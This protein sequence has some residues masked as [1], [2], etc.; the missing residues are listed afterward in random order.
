[1]LLVIDVGNT[2]IALAGFDGERLC[3]RLRI[4]AQKFADLP[5]LW[6]GGSHWMKAPIGAAVVCSVNPPAAR[7]ITYWLRKQHSIVAQTIGAEIPVKMP[8]RC[9]RPEQVGAD[10]LANAV[11]AFAK[12]QSHVVVVDFGTATSFDIVSDRGEF[13]GGVIAP[14]I[15]MSAR[16]LNRET[17]FLPLVPLIDSDVVIG[18]DTVEAITSGLAWG[19]SG[20]VD[21]VVEKIAEE[22]GTDPHV[23][24]TGGDAET[25]APRSKSI[26]EIEPDLTF[27]GIRLIY[28]QS[29]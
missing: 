2:S 21:R 20:L 16:A 5:E 13:L 1:M 19:F 9:K 7:E 11:A 24:A 3:G 4:S 17:V 27:H 6:A 22:L 14:G 8:I 12:T 26:R 15:A 28:E 23:I 25:I 10:R 29:R 18:K